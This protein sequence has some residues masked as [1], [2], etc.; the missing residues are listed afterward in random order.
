MG[1]RGWRVDRGGRGGDSHDDDG[2]DDGGCRA[3]PPSS[4]A[5]GGCV[6]RLSG[7][8]RLITIEREIYLA[9][10]QKMDPLPL[11]VIHARKRAVSKRAASGAN[12]MSA[13]VDR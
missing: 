12:G 4:T 13:F 5:V 2:R 7:D 9:L 11:L 6:F 8:N 1:A 10:P 3:K